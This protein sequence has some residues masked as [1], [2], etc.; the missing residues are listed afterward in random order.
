MKNGLTVFQFPQ[1]LTK[2]TTT[3][4]ETSTVVIFPPTIL[5]ER[6][7]DTFFGFVVLNPLCVGF[8]IHSE[9]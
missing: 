4:G 5:F 6:L 7:H 3:L 2:G 1:C 8:V 9:S